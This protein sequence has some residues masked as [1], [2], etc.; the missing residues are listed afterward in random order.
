M[1]PSCPR[2]V[3]ALLALAVLATPGHAARRGEAA[4]SVPAEVSVCFVP[5]QECDTA[6]VAAIDTASQSIRVQAYGFTA[7]RIL[8]AL[9]DARARGVD[10]QAI[11]DKSNDPEARADGVVHRAHPGGASFTAQAAIPTWID[12]SVAIAHNKVIVIDRHLVI[13]GS[14]NYT[15]SAERKNAENVTFLESAELAALYL[16]NW[17][18]RKAVSH[19]A[20]AADATISQ[21]DPGTRIP[22]RP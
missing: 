22:L 7:A 21:A 13:G 15:A 17:E 16:A 11:L 12:D 19:P 18:S 14:Y 3:L 20:H 2:P 8:H 6:I 5:A 9:A 1:R 4:P 10:V